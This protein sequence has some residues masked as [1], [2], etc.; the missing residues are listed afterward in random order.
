MRKKLLW[1]VFAL[2]ACGTNLFVGGNFDSAGGNTNANGIA[3]W[4]GHDW[5]TIQAGLQANPG[6]DYFPRT[7]TK[8]EVHCIDIRPRCRVRGWCQRS[9]ENVP[10]YP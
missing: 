1:L 10:D 2:T 8:R 5:A 9:P 7:A 4:N 6:C 3:V